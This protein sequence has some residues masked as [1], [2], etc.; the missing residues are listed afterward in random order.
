MPELSRRE[1]EQQR[2]RTEILEAALTVFAQKGYHGA[3]MAQISQS[4]EYPLGTIY[5]FFPG[6]EQIYHELV[7]GKGRELGQILLEI[8]EDRS[9]SP[10]ERIR[11]SLLGNAGFFVRNK[12]FIRIYISGKSHVDAPL[13]TNFHKSVNKMHD[14]MIDLYS[15]LFQEGIDDAEFTAYP[16]REMATL[17]SGIVN[18]SIWVWLAEKEEDAELANRLE[19]AFT[20][21]TGGIRVP[22][23]AKS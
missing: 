19:R 6:K 13:L 18:A 12:E 23:E 1:R 20:I 2:K 4:S 9:L 21:F 3:T 7:I 16:S 5:K 14:K 15:D 11:K 17:F 22:A 10:M 8:S